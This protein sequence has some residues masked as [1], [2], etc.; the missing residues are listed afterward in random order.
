MADLQQVIYITWT[1]RIYGVNLRK[2]V[3]VFSLKGKHTT[4]VLG[5]PNKNCANDLLN[6]YFKLMDKN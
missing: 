1:V 6:S 5:I 3:T 4:S 2:D